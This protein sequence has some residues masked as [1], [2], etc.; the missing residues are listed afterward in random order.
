MFP[1]SNLSLQIVRV[2]V[3]VAIKNLK[4]NA[5]DVFISLYSSH[6][7]CSHLVIQLVDFVVSR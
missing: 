3:W 5:K 6:I 4:V 2:A 1:W 7:C